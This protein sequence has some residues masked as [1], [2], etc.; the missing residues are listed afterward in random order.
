MDISHET[1]SEGKRVSLA[2][3]ERASRSSSS[4]DVVD[5]RIEPVG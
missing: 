3:A 4:W 1:T 5:P 2:Y